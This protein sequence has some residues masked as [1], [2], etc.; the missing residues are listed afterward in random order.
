MLGLGLLLARSDVNKD[1]L[2]DGLELACAMFIDVLD[3]TTS[4]SVECGPVVPG[5]KAVLTSD[6]K[7]AK[8]RSET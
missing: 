1:E 4:E 8:V 2:V 7:V 3:D 6:D 5:E